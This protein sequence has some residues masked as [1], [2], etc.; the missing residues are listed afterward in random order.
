MNVSCLCIGGLGQA[1]LQAGA[2]TLARLHPG[3]TTFELAAPAT[4]RRS[5]DPSLWLVCAQVEGAQVVHPTSFLLLLQSQVA[6]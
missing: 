6:Y 5:G 3:S 2:C 1:K 4:S